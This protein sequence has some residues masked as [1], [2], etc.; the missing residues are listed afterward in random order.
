M[1]AAEEVARCHGRVLCAHVLR[2]PPLSKTRKKK[3]LLAVFVEKNTRQVGTPRNGQF[4][5]C[6]IVVVVVVVAGFRPSVLVVRFSLEIA[7]SPPAKF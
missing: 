7:R 6:F 4:F 5:F 2:L 1:R 3:K